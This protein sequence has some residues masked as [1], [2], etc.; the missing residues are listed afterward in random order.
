MRQM[1]LVAAVVDAKLI[2]K[3]Y[4]HFIHAHTRNRASAACA[5]NNLEYILIER[6]LY[7]LLIVFTRKNQSATHIHIINTAIC[8][9]F[10][11]RVSQSFTH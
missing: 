7:Y 11:D 3:I 2:I 9:V 8:L 6:Q 10:T 1:R 5:G 4:M